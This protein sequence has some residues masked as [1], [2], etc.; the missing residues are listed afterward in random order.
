MTARDARTK[1]VCEELI[2]FG[3]DGLLETGYQMLEHEAIEEIPYRPATR[4]TIVNN[5]ESR[6]I[7][8]LREE[9]KYKTL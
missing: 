2:D 1:D 4:T 5:E 7:K 9:Q 6:L 3:V 8:K